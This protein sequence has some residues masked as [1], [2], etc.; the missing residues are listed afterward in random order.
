MTEEPE[1]QINKTSEPD[2]LGDTGAVRTTRRGRPRNQAREPV[3]EA[4]R[5]GLIVTGRNGEQLTRKRT[6]TGDI[7]DIPKSL[8]PEGW[9]YQWCAASV[10]GNSEV[11][12]DQNLMF[13]ENGWRAVPSERHDGRYMP[14]GHKGNIIRGGQMLME[15]PKALCDEARLEDQRNAI[16][17][18]RDRDQSLMGRKANLRGTIPDGFEMGGKYRGAGGSLR[19][20]IDP[21]LDIPMP[22]HPLAEPG[23]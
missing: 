3:R 1:D 13:Q 4:G 10:V 18:M 9:E 11:L 20:N 15:R 2:M 12:L 16:Q 19:M 8:I 14:V 5:G 7:F 22:S 21:G 6:Q 17:Q 23:E